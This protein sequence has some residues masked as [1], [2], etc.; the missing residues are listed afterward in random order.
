MLLKHYLSVLALLLAA[1][2]A[3]AQFEVQV[4][5]TY[6]KPVVKQNVVIQSWPGRDTLAAGLTDGN[7][8]CP[9]KLG[10]APQQIYVIIR[11]SEQSGYVP[12]AHL[13]DFNKMM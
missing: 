12:V 7:G 1:T 9:I 11:P 6:G 13:V 4:F 8:R 3:T 5:D 2:T 10:L